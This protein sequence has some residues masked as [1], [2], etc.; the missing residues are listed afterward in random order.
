[1]KWPRPAIPVNTAAM[2]P[3]LPPPEDD[4]PPSRRRALVALL[5]LVALV[6]GGWLLA[7]H[8]ASV[9]RTEDCLMAGR[10]NCG[11]SIPSTR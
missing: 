5:L 8:L 10:R 3:P 11:P 7:R 2:P 6:G 1:M 4:P 9:S